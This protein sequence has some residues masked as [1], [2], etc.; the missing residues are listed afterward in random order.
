MPP[1]ARRAPAKQSVPK[2]DP[3]PPPV[4]GLLNWGSSAHWDAQQRPCRHCGSPTHLRDDKGAPA[5]KVCA[6]ASLADIGDIVRTYASQAQ[7]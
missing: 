6:E 7:L 1:R 5:D 4:G 2:L 3:S